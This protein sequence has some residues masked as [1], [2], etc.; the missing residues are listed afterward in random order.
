MNPLTKTDKKESFREADRTILIVDD[1]PLVCW[2]LKN[3]LERAGF[4]V[5][6]TESGEAAIQ[7]LKD[8]FFDLIITDMNLPNKDGFEVAGAGMGRPKQVPVI[9]VTAYGDESARKKAERMGVSYVV[10]K[11][12]D[13]GEMVDLARQLICS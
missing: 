8:S 7:L 3:A 11:P 9:M 13:L 4:E 6:T 5:T 12:F 1:E 2:S 10:D